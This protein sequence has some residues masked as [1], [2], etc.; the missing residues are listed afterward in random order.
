M[1]KDIGRR[2]ASVRNGAQLHRDW[3][4]EILKE[5]QNAAAAV[6]Q[7]TTGCVRLHVTRATIASMEYP[8]DLRRIFGADS[9]FAVVT[10]DTFRTLRADQRTIVSRVLDEMGVASAKVRHVKLYRTQL[11]QSHRRSVLV[12]SSQAPCVSNSPTIACI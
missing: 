8:I 5:N 6:V 9:A 12:Q 3:P 1:Q 11:E 10:R 7:G 4:D 2:S